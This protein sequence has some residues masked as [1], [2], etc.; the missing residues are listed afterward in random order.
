MKLKLFII[1]LII[2]SSAVTGRSYLS[3]TFEEGQTKIYRVAGKEYAVTLRL[4][5][6]REPIR[7]KFIV[8]EEFSKQLED[9]DTDRLMNDVSITIRNIYPNELGEGNDIVRFQIGFPDPPTVIVC[10]DKYCLAGETCEVD[11]CCDGAIVNFDNDS[12]HCGGCGISCDCFEG[13]CVIATIEESVPIEIEEPVEPEEPIESIEPVVE[14]SSEIILEPP[15][16]TKNLIWFILAFLLIIVFF[17]IRFTV[18]R[19]K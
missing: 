11:N 18:A 14:E 2:F 1:F 15:D 6:D 10:G 17:I 7:A 4:V 19:K 5:T 12:N 9:G 3:D 13:E 16:K 8:N